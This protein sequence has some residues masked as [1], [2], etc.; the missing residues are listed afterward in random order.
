M[1]FLLFILAAACATGAGCSN[2]E[3][4]MKNETEKNFL[5]KFGNFFSIK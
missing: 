3:S 1:K 4:R 5:R 2:K